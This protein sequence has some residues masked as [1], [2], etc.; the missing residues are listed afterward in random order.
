MVGTRSKGKGKAREE[1]TED[2]ASV[3]KIAVTPEEAAS[4]PPP[5]S[6]EESE[7]P[8]GMEVDSQAETSSAPEKMTLDERQAKMEQLRLKMVCHM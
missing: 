5:T 7:N 3:E 8:E 2:V 4:T 6:R 1:V